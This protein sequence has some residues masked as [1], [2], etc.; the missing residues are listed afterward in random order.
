VSIAVASGTLSIEIVAYTETKTLD[1]TTSP[2]L[3]STPVR[4]RAGGG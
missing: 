2:T 1:T 4:A 3:R